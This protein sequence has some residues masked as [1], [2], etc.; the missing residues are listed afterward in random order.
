MHYEVTYLTLY[1]TCHV[2]VDT[3]NLFKCY[4]VEIL[5]LSLSSL[6]HIKANGVYNWLVKAASPLSRVNLQKKKNFQKN[7]KQRSFMIS[8]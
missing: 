8:M 4:L 1:L 2:F 7:Y 5:K 3:L 6:L